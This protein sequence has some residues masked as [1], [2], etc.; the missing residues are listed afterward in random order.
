MERDGLESQH[1]GEPI[2]LLPHEVEYVHRA[3][4]AAV[5]AKCQA[6]QAYG[7]AVANSGGD[8]AFDDSAS[9][10]AAEEGSIA[11]SRVAR[12]QR[13]AEAGRLEYPAYDSPAVEIGSRVTISVGGFEEVFDIA[14]RAITGMPT[15]DCVDSISAHGPM[16]LALLSRT[17]GSVVRWTTPRGFVEAKITAI[18]QTAV[19]DFYDTLP[20]TDSI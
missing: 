12:Q 7:E 5:G 9:K 15:E 10:V 19:R 2:G 8:W 16:G 17:V 3:L 6:D 11:D 18:N 1:G 14:S 4:R 20:I 13:L